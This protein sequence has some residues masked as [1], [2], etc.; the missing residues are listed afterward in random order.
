ML[1]TRW[2]TI[3]IDFIVELPELLGYNAVITIVDSIFKRT[4]FI[5]IY[6]T[7]TVE[8]ATRLFLYNI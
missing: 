4:Y 2:D 1:N 6:T 3:S 8:D 5:P 7:I